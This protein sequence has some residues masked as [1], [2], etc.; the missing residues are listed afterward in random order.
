MSRTSCNSRVLNLIAITLLFAGLTA[1]QALTTAGPN[2]PAGVPEDYLITP[3]GYFHPSCVGHLAEGDVLRKDEKVIQH[4]DGSLDSIHVCAYSHFK[5]NGEEVVGDEKATIDKRGVKEPTIGHAWVEYG[6]TS[7][8]TSYGELGSNWYV[9]AA[10]SAN[11]GQTVYLF[12]G[13]EDYNDVVTIIQPVLGWNSDYASA[14]GIASW[15]CCTSGTVYEA[16]PTRVNVGDYIEGYMWDNCASGT[17]SCSSWDVLTY[18]L[19][20]GNYSELMSTS[21]QGQTFNWAFGGVLEVYNIAQCSDYPSSGSFNFINLELYND[22][23]AEYS[24]PGWIITNASSGLT[25]QCS[26]G[27][28]E[29]AAEVTLKY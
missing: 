3:Y 16:T 9:P 12:P 17:L 25:P 29:S 1:A 22:S 20:T 11:N 26:Y 15:N 5:T 4:K 18:D 8:S 27:G 7:T 10:P 19:T 23:F 28:S 6:W 21:S 2:R 24:N 13:L 14:W